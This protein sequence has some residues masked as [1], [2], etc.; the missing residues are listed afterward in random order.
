[1]GEKG[2][3]CCYQYL[4]SQGATTLMLFLGRVTDLEGLTGLD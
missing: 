1:M 3:P 2:F 4:S